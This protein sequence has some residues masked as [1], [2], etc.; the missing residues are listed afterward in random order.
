[1]RLLILLFLVSSCKWLGSM[2]SPYFMGTDFKVP[3][4]TPAFQQGFK[5]GCSSGSYARGNYFY[6]T[7]YGYRYDANMIG[8]PEYR[9]GH[10]RG[11]TWCFTHIN[12][13]YIGPQ[14]SGFNVILPKGAAPFDF[15]TTSTVDNVWDG[16]F[17]GGSMGD[18]GSGNFIAPK[19]PGGINGVFNTLQ[20]GIDGSSTLFNNKELLWAGGSSGQI[21][22]Q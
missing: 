15:S 17:G 4:G 3:D 1:M 9:L 7:R 10:S 21:F 6:R 14:S 16:M 22:G 8:N 18:N 5:D 13:Q 19:T 20:Y 11:Y 12:N 2:G